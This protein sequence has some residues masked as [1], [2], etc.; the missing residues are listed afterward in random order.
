M[1]TRIVI[2]ITRIVRIITRISK[3]VTI[4]NIV[5]RMVRIFATVSRMVSSSQSL[6]GT[7]CSPNW[8]QTWDG[9]FRKLILGMQAEF[10]TIYFSK[11][12]GLP[13]EANTCLV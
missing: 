6:F 1:I 3:I 9:H 4:V 8:T 5:T 13:I 11:G 2:I 12:C 10:T 7:N